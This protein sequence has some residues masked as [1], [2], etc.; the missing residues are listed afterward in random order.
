MVPVCQ[1][2]KQTPG[3]HYIKQNSNVFAAA[4]QLFKHLTLRVQLLKDIVWF[5]GIL[6]TC[7]YCMIFSQLHDMPGT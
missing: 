4:A 5:H 7:L 3:P 1:G 2:Q 6:K